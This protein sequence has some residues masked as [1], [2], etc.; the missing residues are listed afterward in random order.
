MNDT[1]KYIFE[2]LEDREFDTVN[3]IVNQHKADVVFTQQMALDASK[4][5]A[6]S[7]DRLE[8]QQ[9]AGFFKR[10]ASTII[11]KNSENQ[12]LN[13]IDTLQMQKFAW[14]YLKQL[15]QQNLINAQGIA[16]IRNNLATISDHI[17]EIQRFLEP[18]IDTL[19][20]VKNHADLS[21]WQASI[22][23]NKYSLKS[24]PRAFLVLHLTYSFIYEHRNIDFTENDIN[25]L[26]AALVNLE[27]NCD[28]NVELLDFIIE[29]I[30]Q[31]GGD[32]DKY[33][34]IINLSFDG[35]AI[36]S[37][38]IQKNISGIGFSSLYYLSEKYEDII[39]LTGDSEICNSDKA[40]KKIISMFF[41]KEFSGLSTM[42]R[43]RD[44]IGEIVGGSIIA[45]D[46][47]KDANG[48]N[49]TPDYITEDENELNTSPAELIEDEQPECIF[50]LSSLSDI[51]IHTTL[52]KIEGEEDR[53]NYLRSFSLCIENSASLSKQGREFIVLLS[54]K[55][56]YPQLY[57]EIMRISDNTHKDREYW[58]ILQAL[59]NNDDK[60]YTWLIDVFFLL[61]LCQKEIENSQILRI[62]GL[63][64]PAQIKKNIPHILTII[65]ESDE[66]QVLDAAANLA[67][68][69]HG[70]KNIIRYRELRFEQFYAEIE[71]KL[72]S[73][74]DDINP[75]FMEL[76]K[77]AREA[78]NVSCF[79]DMSD[80]GLKEKILS[81]VGKIAYRTGRSIAISSL[82]QIRKKSRESILK[83]MSALREANRLIECWNHPK[84]EFVNEISY[85]D[86]DLDN[87]TTENDDWID[88]FSNCEHQI[89]NTLTAFSD[90]CSKAV[91]QIRYYKK[92]EFDKSVVVMNEKKR[93]GK[94]LQ[95]QEEQQSKQFAS[96]AK[97]DN[98]YCLGIEWRQVD[99]PPCDP[100]KIYH[101]KTDGKIWLI[102]DRHDCCYRSEDRENWQLVK[103]NASDDYISV[104]KLDIVNGVWIILGGGYNKGFYYSSDA[105]TWQQSCFPELSNSYDLSWTED[106]FYFHGLWLW[107]FTQ[108]KEYQYI[109]KGII[110]NSKETATYNKSIVFC[111]ESL[112]APWQR[113]E[114]TPELPEGV[115][116]ESIRSLPGTECLLAF[117]K[118]DWIY[119]RAKKKINVPSFVKYYATGKGWRDCTW[120]SDDNG[121]SNIVITR[122]NDK[123]MCFYSNQLLVSD[124]G[125]EWKLHH[126]DLYVADCF[127]LENFSLFPSYR[128][129]QV[130][131]LSQD[132][133]TFKEIMLENG[134]WRHFS[135]NEQGALS[136]YSPNSHETFLRIGTFIYQIH[137]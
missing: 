101:I 22:V 117:C 76:V 11:G 65:N 54:E 82:N 24:M 105:L 108:H 99:N 75:L 107:R 128:N 95:Q 37:H 51:H 63:L 111:S 96:I 129:K 15:Q 89:E 130:I 100:E 97:G 50:L 60:A 84:I 57:G 122:M 136:V 28:E 27:I 86:Y 1:T 110:L 115:V 40:R 137:E 121:F 85:C 83:N 48:L 30:D 125:Y 70:W 16:V 124:K 55:I 116:V 41:G 19:K 2:P 20:Y 120:S 134:N 79:A 42:Y 127:H 119:T 10:F 6:T 71:N 61:T 126:K 93:I 25:H 4:I 53:R 131:Y 21:N 112:D 62:A 39:N 87:T 81:K 69:T 114:G 44:L 14:H 58:P 106:I 135:A 98:E 45:I 109:E 64:K 92:G 56:G 18:A 26:V 94:L 3:S 104:Q 8:K 34:S 118:Y 133:K 35:H 77:A 132:A 49:T 68:H 29:L 52:D 38:F 80:F 7:Q 88:R 5:I 72:S 91:E 102:V 73:A 47:Y 46:I 66:N 33:N 36:G 113:W 17:I 9:N 123:L 12:M 32:I 13:Q 43:I 67:K 78:H 31:I 23:A 90:A 103:P 74:E 59:L